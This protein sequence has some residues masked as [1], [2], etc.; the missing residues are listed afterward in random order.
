MSY[1]VALE[2]IDLDLGSRSVD[3]SSRSVDLAWV[4]QVQTACV[5]RV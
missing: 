4:E 5:Y 3:V 2:Y 1:S